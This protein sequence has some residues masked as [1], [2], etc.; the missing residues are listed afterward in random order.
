MP[1][2]LLQIGDRV[3]VPGPTSYLQRLHDS[4]WENLAKED[5]E[6]RR[7]AREDATRAKEEEESKEKDDEEEKDEDEDEAKN[8]EGSDNNQKGK[9]EEKD[10]KTAVDPGQRA[11]GD[12]PGRQGVYS[13][14]K[15]GPTKGK[16]EGS[17]VY[18]SPEPTGE[19]KGLQKPEPERKQPTGMRG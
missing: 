13:D 17:S 10:D 11:K 8:G 6:R 1:N 3:A 16:G 19:K 2:Y 14:E 15:Q 18:E 5:E 9:S 4:Q 12:K 7:R